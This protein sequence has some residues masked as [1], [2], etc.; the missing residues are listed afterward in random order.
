MVT[1]VTLRPPRSDAADHQPRCM[2]GA[3]RPR[4]VLTRVLRLEEGLDL[5]QAAG[6]APPMGGGVCASCAPRHRVG[7]STRPE[8]VQAEVRVRQSDTQTVQLTAWSRGPAGE[9]RRS[10]R[11][12]RCRHP[13][14]DHM[15]PVQ[16]HHVSN[17][18]VL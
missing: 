16:S 9:L 12:L 5:Q 10:A 4:G 6:R 18:A 2:P 1:P 14:P 7:R 11:G 3:R 17:Q 8:A 15:D 13:G